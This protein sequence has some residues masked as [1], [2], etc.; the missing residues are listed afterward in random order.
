M[1]VN[2]HYCQTTDHKTEVPRDL[3]RLSNAV[4][5]KWLG[6]DAG[7]DLPDSRTYFLYNNCAKTFFRAAKNTFGCVLHFKK[8]FV[9]RVR[10]RAVGAIGDSGCKEQNYSS[11]QATTVIIIRAKRY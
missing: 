11:L 10:I 2:D 9:K 8:M 6:G 7:P 1:D 4:S 5:G 3:S